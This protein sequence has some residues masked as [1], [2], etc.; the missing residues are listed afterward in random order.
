MNQLKTI[1]N[2]KGKKKAQLR[3]QKKKTMYTKYESEAVTNLTLVHG[4]DVS[5]LKDREIISQIKAHKKIISDLSEA[6]LTGAYL[7]TK[8]K[9]NEEAIKALQAELNS[10]VPATACAE[11]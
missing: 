1:S 11:A 6:G 3:A 9:E 4:Q 10:R 5:E 2:H 7:V 8:S